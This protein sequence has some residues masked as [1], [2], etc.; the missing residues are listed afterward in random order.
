MLHVQPLST[1][2]PEY[3]NQQWKPQET[4]SVQVVVE[5]A[6]LT[7]D[8]YAS[9]QEHPPHQVECP[10]KREECPPKREECP[11]K[12]EE[13]PPKREECPPKR[14]E[15]PPKRE[16]CPPKKEECPPKDGC[17]KPKCPPKDPCKKPCDPCA[18][19]TEMGY[20]WGWLGA[21]ILWFI[22]FTVLFWLIY[23]SL[24][25]SF[26]LQT[27]SNQVDTG[28]VLLAAVISALILVIIIWLIKAAVSR[29][30]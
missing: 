9:K 2:A 17:G 26:V 19:G 10:P 4:V 15:C 11:P 22:I 30:Y 20:G 13:C 12:K 29:R 16:E 18:K 27:D 21:L 7:L 25:P 23:Y 14:E 3:N 24:K 28:K 1:L 5:E 8:N 6:T